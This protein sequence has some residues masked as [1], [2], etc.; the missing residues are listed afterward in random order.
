MEFPWER[1][2]KQEEKEKS[3]NRLRGRGKKVSLTRIRKGTRS[4]DP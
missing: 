1:E 2:E 3:F 4:G